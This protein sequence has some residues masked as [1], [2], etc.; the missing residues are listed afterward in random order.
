M[1]YT[2]ESYIAYTIE[3]FFKSCECKSWAICQ[4]VKENHITLCI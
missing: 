4:K 1:V 3:T 2:A